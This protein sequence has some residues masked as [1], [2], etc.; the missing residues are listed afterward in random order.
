M[1]P[2]RL[3]LGDEVA[4]G[5]HETIVDH[6]SVAGAFGAQ[7]LRSEA[8]LGDDRMQSDDGRKH[9]VEI[10]TV[11]VGARLEGLR[12]FPLA[13]R[14]HRNSPVHF[15]AS[16]TLHCG[17]PAPEFDRRPKQLSSSNL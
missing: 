2:D 3:S 9:A 1:Q 14:G 8:V 13:G 16:P 12:Y 6:D 15:R 7:R 5:E 11:I 4:D 17:R 10:E